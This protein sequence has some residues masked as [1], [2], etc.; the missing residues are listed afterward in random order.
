MNAAALIPAKRACGALGLPYDTFRKWL[1]VTDP[2]PL[3]FI[4]DHDVLP[5]GPG[6]RH[7]MSEESAVQLAVAA[8]LWSA[9]LA[10]RD[11]LR[12]GWRYALRSSPMD[13]LRISDAGEI[14]DFAAAKDEHDRLPPRPFQTGATWV[15]AT[16]AGDFAVL[17]LCEGEGFRPRDLLYWLWTEN[18]CPKPGP[19]E[20]LISV[21]TNPLHS[22][23]DG[24]LP[25]GA[26]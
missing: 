5:S 14:T 9:G 3:P 10:P 2:E 11:A 26:P 1:R 22:I 12:V 6:S 24:L 25:G 8:R 17:R 23:I 18:G 16:P 7:L 4:S 13:E 20:T 19:G 15:V 21:H